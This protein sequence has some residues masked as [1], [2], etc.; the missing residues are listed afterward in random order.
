[1]S[2][3][4]NSSDGDTD[5]ASRFRVRN[6]MHIAQNDDFTVARGQGGERAAKAR[7]LLRLGQVSNRISLVAL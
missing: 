4:A 3:R 7:R 2:A 5:D 1:M 6:A